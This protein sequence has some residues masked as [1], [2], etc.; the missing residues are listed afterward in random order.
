MSLLG[1]ARAICSSQCPRLKSFL[2]CS[3]SIHN[4]SRSNIF[5]S[6]LNFKAENASDLKVLNHYSW[7]MLILLNKVQTDKK[8]YCDFQ[9]YRIFLLGGGN[10]KN[11]LWKINGSELCWFV[12]VIL[13]LH[14]SAINVS[15]KFF[16][17]SEP[18]LSIIN[19]NHS[20]FGCHSF[21]HSFIHLWSKFMNPVFVWASQ[22]WAV[23]ALFTFCEE[24]SVLI[25]TD[26]I[27]NFTYINGIGNYIHTVKDVVKLS[28]H[29]VHP[30][31]HP[32]RHPSIHGWRHC[33]PCG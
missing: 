24:P 19:P 25:L 13:P 31:I 29:P 1:D 14:D 30:S 23:L 22:C 33:S 27:P 6:P 10:L 21:I 4:F 28:I 17:C 26:S 20:F 15:P 2:A 8:H 9:V 32:S 11:K 12:F 16:T 3:R 7:S 18:H 5:L